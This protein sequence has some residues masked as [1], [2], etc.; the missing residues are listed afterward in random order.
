[1]ECIKAGVER[2][3]GLIG[4]RAVSV[5]DMPGSFPCDLRAGRELL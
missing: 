3:L 4:A 2:D 5:N 1:M